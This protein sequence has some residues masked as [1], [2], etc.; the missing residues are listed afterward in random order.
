MVII[1]KVLTIAKTAWL[2]AQ[3]QQTDHM[4]YW[5]PAILI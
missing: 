5:A 4:L 2:L 1:A 3:K